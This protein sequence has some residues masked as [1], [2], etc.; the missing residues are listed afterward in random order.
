MFAKA[1]EDYNCI[2][3]VL[4]FPVQALNPS[5]QRSNPL[6]YMELTAGRWVADGYVWVCGCVAV[7]VC[8]HT[9]TCIR[10]YIHVAS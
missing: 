5:I 4:D 7:S 6:V 8:M 10:M 2:P 9:H 1:A 3:P